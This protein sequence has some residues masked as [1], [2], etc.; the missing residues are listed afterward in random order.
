MQPSTQTQ[1]AGAGS[2]GARQLSEAEVAS[3]KRS[4]EYIADDAKRLANLN[5]HAPFSGMQD[6]IDRLLPFHVSKHQCIL[7]SL[8]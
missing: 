7:T 3:Q 2:N 1:A 8:L 5:V 6:A 4:L